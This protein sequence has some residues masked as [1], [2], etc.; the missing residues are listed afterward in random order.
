MIGALKKIGWKRKTFGIII[1]VIPI[2]FLNLVRNASV[3]FLVGANITTFNIA[4]NI[5]A[6][7]GALI[8]LIA[9]LFITFKI[10]PE[11]FDEINCIIDLPKRK[12]PIE[13]FFKGKK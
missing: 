4:H 2:Y 7:I 5:L 11:L 6:K 10:I 12:G 3:V 9:L 13:L 8:T 1:T